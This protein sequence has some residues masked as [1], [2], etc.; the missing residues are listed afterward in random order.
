[1]ENKTMSNSVKE[2]RNSSGKLKGRNVILRNIFERLTGVIIYKNMKGSKCCPILYKNT[3]LEIGDN[4]K[5]LGINFKGKRV[6]DR[7]GFNELIKF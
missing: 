1:M 6:T 3:E 7:Y 5:I 4:Y 2:F